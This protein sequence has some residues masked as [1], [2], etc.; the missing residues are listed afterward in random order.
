MEELL[1]GYPM[2]DGKVVGREMPI[3]TTEKKKETKKNESN[4][5]DSKEP[6]E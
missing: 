3:E 1:G 6:N 2:V 5:E 4:K